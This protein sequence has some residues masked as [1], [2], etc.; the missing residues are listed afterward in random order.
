MST[1]S[2]PR[3]HTLRKSASVRH[4]PVNLFASVMGIAGLS[5]AWRQAS[6]AFGASP[7]I[8]EGAGLLA[9]AVFVV[10]GAGYLVKAVR[11]PGGGG[12]RVPAPGGGEFLRH[13]HHRHPAAVYGGRS[14]EPGAGRGDVDRGHRGDPRHLLR[15]LQPT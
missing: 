3:P 15:Q 7:L 1:L 13:H 5:L 12:Q 8:A 14:A 9:L 10:L 2:N 4:L 6:R 11:L